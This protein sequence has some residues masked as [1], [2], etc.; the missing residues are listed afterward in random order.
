[1]QALQE[2]CTSGCCR[3]QSRRKFFAT[4]MDIGFQVLHVFVMAIAPGVHG[5]LRV[6]VG[7]CVRANGEPHV[8]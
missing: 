3:A 6:R 1:M 7:V 8:I 4:S 5:K 2:V